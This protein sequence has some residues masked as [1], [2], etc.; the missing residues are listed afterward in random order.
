[1]LFEDRIRLIL[2]MYIL[3]HIAAASSLPYNILMLAFCPLGTS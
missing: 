3:L 2:D 1:M